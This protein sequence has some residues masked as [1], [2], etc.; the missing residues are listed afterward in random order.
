MDKDLSLNNLLELQEKQLDDCWNCI[1]REFDEETI[2]KGR[3]DK[4]HFPGQNFGEARKKLF[5]TYEIKYG[6]FVYGLKR[7]DKLLGI[8]FAPY[9]S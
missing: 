6:I 4:H 8:S 2:S 3:P 1:K 5:D 9:S 7:S